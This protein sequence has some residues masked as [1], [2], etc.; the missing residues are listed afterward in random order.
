MYRYDYRAQWKTNFLETGLFGNRTG[1]FWNGRNG[2][3]V[4]LERG[5]G[6]RWGSIPEAV[7]FAMHKVTFIA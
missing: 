2:K 6:E 7:I 5:G 4:L 1:T 3:S